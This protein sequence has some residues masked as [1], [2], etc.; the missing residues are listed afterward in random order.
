[1]LNS[2]GIIGRKPA[3]ITKSLKHW[4]R[5]SKELRKA[6]RKP[7]LAG[8]NEVSGV[9]QSSQVT[10]SESKSQSQRIRNGN[11]LSQGGRGHG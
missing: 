8:A 2:E 4:C 10:F 7:G 9:L 11:I 5:S 3:H 6:L 1:M